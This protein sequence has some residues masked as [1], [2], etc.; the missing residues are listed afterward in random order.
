MRHCSPQ[1]IKPTWDRIAVKE[2]ANCANTASK[3]TTQ[4]ETA[5]NVV[6]LGN[7]TNFQLFVLPMDCGT[8]VI[9]T[10]PYKIM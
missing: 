8:T 3:I 9:Q 2:L 10:R 4:T 6:L 1:L 7:L 5:L